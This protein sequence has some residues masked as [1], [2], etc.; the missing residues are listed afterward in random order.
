MDRKND[1]KNQTAEATGE[2][3]QRKSAIDVLLKY[4]ETVDQLEEM[5]SRY[6]YRQN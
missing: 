6:F 2:A 5:R 1:R 4:V 3:E